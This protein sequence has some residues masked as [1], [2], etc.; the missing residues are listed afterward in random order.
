MQSDKQATPKESSRESSPKK[1]PKTAQKAAPKKATAK[2]VKK[3]A[4]PK[5][6]AA[7]SSKSPDKIKIRFEVVYTTR[8]GQAIFI[9]GEHPVLGASST[10][11][12]P[13]LQY[14]DHQKWAV[15]LEFL[16]DSLQNGHIEYSYI[17]RYED[18]NLSS[19]APYQL[20]L[21]SN[22]AQLTVRDAWNAP[23]F[24]ENVYLTDAM[25]AFN[26]EAPIPKTTSRK[27]FSHRFL[28]SAPPLEEGQAVCLIGDNKELGGWDPAKALPMIPAGRGQWSINVNFKGTALN[29][30]YKY[31]VYDL[32]AKTLLQY[33]AG[34]NREITAADA[35]LL[36]LQDGFLRNN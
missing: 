22:V 27:K 8:F 10:D 26:V 18:G 21:P 34:A 4:T 35:P 29:G 12:A 3:A 24:M 2:S 36:I 11:K 7:K 6:P 30:C 9:S 16:K 13:A 17:I 15:E 5:K 31:G 23:G 1:T 14:I 25:Q 28:I 19:S 33:E 20:T 32:S